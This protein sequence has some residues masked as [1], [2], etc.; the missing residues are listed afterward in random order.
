M[1]DR[2]EGWR[3]EEGDDHSPLGEG[4]KGDLGRVNIGH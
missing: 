4:E 2:E 1:M 3:Q